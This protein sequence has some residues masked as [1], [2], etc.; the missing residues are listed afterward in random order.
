[1]I[2]RLLYFQANHKLFNIYQSVG[3][4]FGGLEK[5]TQK[6]HRIWTK[7]VYNQAVQHLNILI[8]NLKVRIFE[9]F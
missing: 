3:G 6:L 7:S 8:W 9:N 4:E 2:Y 5:Q 1:M